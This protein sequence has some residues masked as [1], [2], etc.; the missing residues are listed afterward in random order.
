M[1]LSIQCTFSLG[2]TALVLPSAIYMY[3]CLG[4]LSS[5]TKISFKIVA[6]SLSCGRVELPLIKRKLSNGGQSRSPRQVYMA[7][8]GCHVHLSGTEHVHL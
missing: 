5:I 4:V 1:D 7:V 6:T 3:T 2:I 8:H